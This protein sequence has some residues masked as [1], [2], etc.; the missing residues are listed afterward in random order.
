VKR[1]ALGTIDY[2][3]REIIIA[4]PY[5]PLRKLPTDRCHSCLQYDAEILPLVAPMPT[6]AVLPVRMLKPTTVAPNVR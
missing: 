5:D 2:L 3:G 6:L 4:Q 1:D